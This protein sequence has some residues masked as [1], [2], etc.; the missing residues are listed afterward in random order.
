MVCQILLGT[1]LVLSTEVVCRVRSKK[2]CVWSV[3]SNGCGAGWGQ[4]HRKFPGQ[5]PSPSAARLLAGLST[6]NYG[7]KCGVVKNGKILCCI[8]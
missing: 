1:V 6:M 7:I 4:R 3:R 2:Q 8:K 5:V